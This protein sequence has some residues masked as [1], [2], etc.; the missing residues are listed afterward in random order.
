MSWESNSPLKFVYWKFAARAQAAMLMCHAANIEYEW[1]EPP[2]NWKEE[3]GKYPFGQLP[4]LKHSGKMIPQSGTMT[5][6]CANL[7][8]LMPD[9]IEHQLDADMLIEFSNDIYSLFAKAKYAGDELHQQVA[10]QR[11]EKTQLP[12]K[13]DYLVKFLDSKTFFSGDTIH[14][15]DIAIFSILNLATVAGIKWEDKYPTIKSHY[16]RVRTIGTI[17][18]YLESQP[19]PYFTVA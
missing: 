14:A 12:E 1:E 2:E 10:W 15:G 6:Y 19:K 8:S 18:K 4:C 16:D 13:L 7:S 3:K 17:E 9:N 11:V 5:R